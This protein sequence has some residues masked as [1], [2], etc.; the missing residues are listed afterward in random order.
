VG[1]AHAVDGV[2]AGTRVRAIWLVVSS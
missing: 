2:D 1:G